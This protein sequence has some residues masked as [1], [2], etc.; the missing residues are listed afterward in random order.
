MML[1]GTGGGGAQRPWE[2]RFYVNA[3]PQVVSHVWQFGASGFIMLY[4]TSIT[5]YTT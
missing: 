3:T 5:V 4:E 2:G 1:T